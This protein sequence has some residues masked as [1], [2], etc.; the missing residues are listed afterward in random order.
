MQN[1]YEKSLNRRC[2]LTGLK[3]R[4]LEKLIP[5]WA[6]KNRDKQ[7][8]AEDKQQKADPN[9]CNQTYYIEDR[10][11]G[12]CIKCECARPINHKGEHMHREWFN[13]CLKE[14]PKMHDLTMTKAE[15]TLENNI[16]CGI[17]SKFGIIPDFIRPYFSCTCSCGCDFKDNGKNG[18]ICGSCLNNDHNCRSIGD[19]HIQAQGG[20]N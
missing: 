14:Y 20:F 8:K 6:E 4:I 10:F 7:Q 9:I 11:I 1:L 16:K 2:R 18:K 19:L 13:L 12:D 5:N 17:T 15:Q 3:L